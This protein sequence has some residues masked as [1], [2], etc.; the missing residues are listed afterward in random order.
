MQVAVS[1]RA[2]PLDEKLF[3]DPAPGPHDPSCTAVPSA[4]LIVTN[5][6][7]PRN[8]VV[9]IHIYLQYLKSHERSGSWEITEA[10]SF[11]AAARRRHG[12]G[13]L[14]RRKRQRFK[15]EWIPHRQIKACASTR[16]LIFC[17]A[18]LSYEPMYMSCQDH[19]PLSLLKRGLRPPSRCG[20]SCATERCEPWRRACAT[21]RS[22]VL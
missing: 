18:T 7:L 2:P 4:S 3:V 22:G 21:S 14:D 11:A 5:R 12:G 6:Y 16:R 19:K 20:A 13:V 17:F 8:S 9:H 1:R 15:V 10:S